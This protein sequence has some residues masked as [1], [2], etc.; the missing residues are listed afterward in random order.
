MIK[1]K[2]IL[3]Y[4]LSSICILSFSLS[5]IAIVAQENKEETKVLCAENTEEK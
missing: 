2:K 3:I 4:L 1:M 5:N